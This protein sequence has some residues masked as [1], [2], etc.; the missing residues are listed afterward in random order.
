[1][2]FHSFKLGDVEDPDLYSNM[3]IATWQETKLGSW[4]MKNATQLAYKISTVDD[5]SGYRVDI[6]GKLSTKKTLIYFLKFA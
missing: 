1:M 2:V 6:T 4:C 3:A 5:Y